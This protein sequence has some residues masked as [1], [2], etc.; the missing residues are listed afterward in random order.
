MSTSGAAALPPRAVRVRV[1]AS[2]ANLGPGFDTLGMALGRYDHIEVRTLAEPGLSVDVTDAGAGGIEDVPRDESHLVVRVL[3]RTFD[4]LGIAPAGLALRCENTIPHARGLGSSAAAV[5]AGAAAAYALADQP[6][7]TDAVLRIAA[8][9]EGHVDNAAASLL[10]GA[11]IAWQDEGGGR[12][13]AE[14]IPPDPTIRPVVAIPEQRSSTDATRGL[15]PETVPHGDAV[16]SAG[17]AALAVHALT[18]AP[19][20]L[21][22]AT[23]DRLHQHYR[24]PAYP[25]TAHLIEALRKSGVA[26]AV[27]GAGPTVLALTIDGCIPEDVDTS[28]FTLVELP[29]DSAGVTV[30]YP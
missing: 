27:S 4:H 3:R 18:A 15:L 6:L 16:F 25:A 29:I 20:L 12:W 7:D 21:V 5:V 26:A 19:E 14:R 24:A 10:G 13:H 28:G 11:V 9:F 17:R 2:T 1:P 8:E 30:T 22:A 23:A